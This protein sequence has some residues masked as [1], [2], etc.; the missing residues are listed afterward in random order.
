MFPLELLGEDAS[1]GIAVEDPPIVE[2][3]DRHGQVVDDGVEQCAR[4]LLA[5]HRDWGLALL[6]SRP[7]TPP[8]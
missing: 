2:H 7:P 1:R 6:Y 3:H 5:D 4:Q 8:P